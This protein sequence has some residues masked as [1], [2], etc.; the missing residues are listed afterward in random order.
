MQL[1]VIHSRDAGESLTCTIGAGMTRNPAG[2]PS[3]SFSA[4]TQGLFAVALLE[5]AQWML[6]GV[7]SV[8]FAACTPAPRALPDRL[9]VI[10]GR[11]VE[12]LDSP[13][14]SFVRLATTASGDVWVG[15]PGAQYPKEAVVHVR[16]AAL[17][18]NHRLVPLGRTLEAV[19]FG[20]LAS[21]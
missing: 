13:P 18:R 10:E 19:Y 11:V 9:P 8:G 15:V 17:V 7:A 1:A 20:R 21:E 2:R 4:W 16:D 3:L 14:Y 12:R 5:T 6:F